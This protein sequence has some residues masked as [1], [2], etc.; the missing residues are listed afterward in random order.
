MKISHFPF[1]W[2]LPVWGR[3]WHGLQRCSCCLWS[4]ELVRT[5]IQMGMPQLNMGK[6]GWV[7][8]GSLVLKKPI[9]R[10]NLCVSKSL[11]MGSMGMLRNSPWVHIKKKSERERQFLVWRIISETRGRQADK[12][13][14]LKSCLVRR[15]PDHQI[16]LCLDQI[17]RSVVSDS[18]RSHELQHARPPVH[19]QLPEFTETH[20]HQVSDA[21]QPSHPLSSPSPPA[22]S[23]SQHQSLFQWVNSSHEVAKVLEFQL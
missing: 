3:G 23:P 10:E 13:P 9:D 6:E 21:I 7:T 22:P 2:H 15:C 14:E 12:T 18:L 5:L 4:A 17:S 8:K 16:V 1:S 11:K 19:H 20:V